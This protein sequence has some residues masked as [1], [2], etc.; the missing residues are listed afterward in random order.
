[1]GQQFFHALENSRRWWRN[2]K[3]GHGRRE[4]PSPCYAA[5]HQQDGRRDVFRPK[6]D[7][8]VSHFRN[9]IPLISIRAY[10]FLYDET[11]A[12]YSYN[13]MLTSF[14][15]DD[16]IKNR[17]D[18]APFIPS[19]QGGSH[20]IFSSPKRY[21]LSSGMW[22]TELTIGLFLNYD[23]S[24]WFQWEKLTFATVKNTNSLGL[25]LFLVLPSGELSE[26]RRLFAKIAKINYFYTFR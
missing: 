19:G 10:T 13:E 20:R 23:L 6:F 22:L 11:T 12:S 8:L 3:F 7:D 17:R 5:S 4:L 18:R 24:H 14:L 16:R 15:R 9:A 25:G 2:R 26:F 1:M 21:A